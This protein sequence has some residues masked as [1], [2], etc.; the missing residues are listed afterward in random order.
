MIDLG[1]IAMPYVYQPTAADKRVIEDM[2]PDWGLGSLGL[3]PARPAW[4]QDLIDQG[5]YPWW[6]DEQIRTG[7]SRGEIYLEAPS[8]GFRF[9]G[10]Q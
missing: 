6:L 8:H 5:V 1:A 10:A 2:S 4:A 3:Q 9:P 7:R